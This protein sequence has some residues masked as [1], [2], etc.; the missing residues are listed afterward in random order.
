MYYKV[1]HVKIMSLYVV[2]CLGYDITGTISCIKVMAE[3]KE[4]S[5]C[6]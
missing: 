5:I 2:T 1:G 3:I 6:H 4:I